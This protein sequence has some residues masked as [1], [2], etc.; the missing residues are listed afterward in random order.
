MDKNHADGQGKKITV[1]IDKDLEELIPSYLE[2]TRNDVNN[3]R[4]SLVQQDFE[5][6]RRAGHTLKGSGSSYGFD[7][8]SGLGA[9]IEE[10][11]KSRDTGKISEFTNQ[12]EQ[13]LDNIHIVFE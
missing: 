12:L 5:T 3:I 2:L 11:A 6:V 4:Q 10:Y 13:Y 8:I 7:A 9:K 1:Y